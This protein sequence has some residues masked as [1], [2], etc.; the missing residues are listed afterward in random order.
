MDFVVGWCAIGPLGIVVLEMD[1]S[2]E[3]VEAMDLM[4]HVEAGDICVIPQAVDFWPFCHNV[5]IIPNVA[6][7]L[8]GD[9]DGVDVA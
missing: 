2:A 6:D 9:G 8:R 4:K 7:I 5:G 3:H 1:F